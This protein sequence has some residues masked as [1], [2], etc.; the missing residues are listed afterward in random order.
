MSIAIPDQHHIIFKKLCSYTEDQVTTIAEILDNAPLTFS[1]N[2]ILE[3]FVVK[4]VNWIERDD[5]SNIIDVLTSLFTFRKAQLDDLNDDEFIKLLLDSAIDDIDKEYDWSNLK[6][7]FN[8]LFSKS[9]TIKVAG[10][11]LDVTSDHSCVYR[12]SRILS[13]IRPIFY[14]EDG[15]ESIVTTTTTHT[16]KITYNDNNDSKINNFYIALDIN[17][18][19]NLQEIVERAIEKEKKLIDFL[20]AAKLSHLNSEDLI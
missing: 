9:K 3:L 8:I 10:K 17:D 14:D 2:E 5:L 16:L 18:L 20:Q 6:N 4:K 15:D 7:I 1:T 19:K 12:D 13:D 11:A